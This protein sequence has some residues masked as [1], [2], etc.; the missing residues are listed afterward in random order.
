[1][2]KYT[3]KHFT[4]LHLHVSTSP[5]TLCPR[6]RAVLLRHRATILGADTADLFGIVFLILRRGEDSQGQMI[7]SY[8]EI[9]ALRRPSDRP[10]G[11]GRDTQLLRDGS[12]QYRVMTAYT[13]LSAPNRFT[14]D[15]L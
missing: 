5:L 1:M 14:Y 13:Q 6:L 3:I 12:D 10:R 4:F 7:G 9:F 8:P 15:E 2:R 11:T